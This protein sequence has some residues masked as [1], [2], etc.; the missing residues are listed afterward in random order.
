VLL[1]G[2]VAFASAANAATV[3]AKLASVD[4]TVFSVTVVNGSNTYTES[5][6]AGQFHWDGSVAGGSNPAGL[7]GAF[8]SFCIDLKD[9]VSI[10]GTFTYTLSDLQS[11]P[12]LNGDGAGINT[13]LAGG[14]GADKANVLSLLFGQHYKDVV[15]ADTAGAFQAAIWE[16][17]YED[18]VPTFADYDVKTLNP[19]STTWGFKVNSPTSVTATAND[20]LHGLNS[21][22]PRMSL[23]AIMSDQ[24]QDQIIV[25]P[26]PS[27]VT[28][29][30]GLLGTLGLAGIIQ[31]RRT[32]Q[33]MV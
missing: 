26:T 1:A 27:A 18:T 19:G 20:W 14:M 13:G 33:A 6:G 21:A 2:V 17:V 4:M 11:A 25:V 10:G 29:G 12:I 8:T 9:W 31:R 7:N 23:A 24:Y 16:I 22:G 28:A 30:F 32:S 3:K 5:G 15:N